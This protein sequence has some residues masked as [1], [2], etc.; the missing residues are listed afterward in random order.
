MLTQ[1]DL[2]A[3]IEMRCEQH[4]REENPRRD[5]APK[6]Q[7]QMQAQGTHPRVPA[8]P[9]GKPSKARQFG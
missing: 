1:D 9:I 4:R 8:V 2:D 3:F 5:K 6:P 7:D